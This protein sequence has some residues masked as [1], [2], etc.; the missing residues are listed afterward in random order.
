MFTKLLGNY[1][2][3]LGVIRDRLTTLRNIWTT[4]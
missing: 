1:F 2:S 3:E 4:H